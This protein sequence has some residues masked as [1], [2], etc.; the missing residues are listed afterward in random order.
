MNQLPFAAR[1]YIAFCL[2]A[3]GYFS[4]AALFAWPSP[5][6]PV[7]F[8][9]QFWLDEGGGHSY[10]SGSYHGRSSGGFSGGGK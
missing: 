1:A 7:V 3:C 2:T 4:S 5:I 8:T 10:S 9:N 6:P